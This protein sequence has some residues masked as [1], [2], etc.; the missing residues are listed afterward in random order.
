MRRGGKKTVLSVNENIVCC[1]HR[2]DG[3]TE[4]EL[5]AAYGVAFRLKIALKH[6]LTCQLLA[7]TAR[8]ICRCRSKLLML[9]PQLI[10]GGA[11]LTEAA[12]QICRSETAVFFIC[13]Y[14]S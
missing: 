4:S 6:A 8:C 14:L 10:I 13:F 11:D 5:M 9:L 7:N 1:H 12:F 3:E 2:G